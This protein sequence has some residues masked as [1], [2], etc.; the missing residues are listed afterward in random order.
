M[1]TPPAQKPIGNPASSLQRFPHAPQFPG[2]VCSFTQLPPHAV[3]PGGHGPQTPP[4][5]VPDGQTTAQPPQLFESVCGLTHVK[6]EAGPGQAT[7]PLRQHTPFNRVCPWGHAQ[8]PLWQIPP[9]GQVVLQPPQKLGSVA[10]F[11][12]TSLHVVSPLAH[13]AH[14]PFL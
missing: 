2:S 7:S 6:K 11:A 12:Q 13:D 14:V 10:S 4:R 1:Q 3:S 5:Q 8:L 9:I